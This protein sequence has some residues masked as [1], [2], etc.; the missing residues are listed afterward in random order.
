MSTAT[1]KSDL[2]IFV[3]FVFIIFYSTGA[4][5]LESF[6]NYPLW[7][8]IGPSE[9]WTEYRKALG[10]KIIPVLAVPSLLVSLILNVIL[11]IKRPVEIPV[12][13]VWA[14]LGFLAVAF[15]S[16]VFIQLPIQAKLDEGYDPKLLDRLIVS[17]FW[18][19]EMMSLLRIGVVFY[20][21]IA[22][23]RIR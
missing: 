6:V 12:W 21:M 22:V 19:R 1:S 5:F 11:F 20:M 23:Y 15:I 16:T 8:I 3:L 9:Q 2:W 13:T 7:K 10:P 14:C 18:L 4:G 17:S